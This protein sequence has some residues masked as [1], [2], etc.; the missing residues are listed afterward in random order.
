MK[1]TKPYKL[2]HWDRVDVLKEAAQHGVVQIMSPPKTPDA[3][4][5]F[6]AS[7]GPLMF[8][9]GEIPVTGHPLLNVVTNANR[10]TKPKSTFHSDTSYI[11]S[12]PSNSALMAIEVPKA[13]GATLFSDQYAALDSLDHDL[14]TLLQG[15]EVLHTATG[16]QK[17]QSEWHPLVRYNPQSGRKALFLTSIARCK[18]LR[19]A[20][21]TDRT[22]LLQG[23][24]DKSLTNTP[25]IKHDW[26]LGDV[27]LWDNRSTMHAADHSDVQGT[28]TLFRGL[29]RGEEP[30]CGGAVDMCNGGIATPHI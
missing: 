9:E 29:I 2:Y 15:A 30:I 10:K 25:H 4:L 8:T 12:P 20:D 22:D 11:S 27:L 19:L 5:N 6:L 13:G 7:L 28:R 23:L 24:Y 3:F 26:S 18:R 16:V 14:R 21:G 1:T 17:V